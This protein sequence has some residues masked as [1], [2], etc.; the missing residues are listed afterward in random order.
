LG[1]TGLKTDKIHLPQEVITLAAA[2]NTIQ[3]KNITAGKTKT[4][5]LNF[6]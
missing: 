6:N 4:L 5:F 2:V 1:I 3:T